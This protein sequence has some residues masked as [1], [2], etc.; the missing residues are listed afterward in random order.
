[1]SGLDIINTIRL[2]DNGI[3]NQNRD[4]QYDLDKRA[5]RLEHRFSELGHK[6]RPLDWDEFKEKHPPVKP[7]GFIAHAAGWALTG[8][9]FGAVGLP[10]IVAIE[11]VTLSPLLLAGASALGAVIGTAGGA[12]LSTFDDQ[13]PE[14]RK[15]QLEKYKDHLDDFEQQHTPALEQHIA[16]KKEGQ[17]AQE[18]DAESRKWR[19]MAENSISIATELAV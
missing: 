10:I 6:P 11:A 14:I 7:K 19:D 15:L 4:M 3:S 8:A 5:M 18:K 2:E 9:A 1:M 16:M 12:L 17:A 13:K